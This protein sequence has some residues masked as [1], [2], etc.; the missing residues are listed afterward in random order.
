[1]KLLKL[2]LLLEEIKAET[3][4]FK[5]M[6]LFVKILFK[7]CLREEK[8]EAE[9]KHHRELWWRF[10]SRTPSCPPGPWPAGTASSPSGAAQQRCS[11]LNSHIAESLG[12]ASIKNMTNLSFW[13]NL[14]WP[15]S[16]ILR[17]FFR[18]CGVLGSEQVP[19]VTLGWNFCFFTFYYLDLCDPLA[20]RPR[21][22]PSFNE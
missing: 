14:R 2:D 17:V 4:G 9:W 20:T 12:K 1:M 18:Q 22:E 8:T 5:I 11:S 13:L 3:V 19:L 7:F 21:Q 10:S 6:F 16:S 15:L